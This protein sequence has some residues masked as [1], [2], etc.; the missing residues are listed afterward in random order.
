MEKI[1]AIIAFVTLGLVSGTDATLAEAPSFEPPAEAKIYLAKT[2]KPAFTRASAKPP[3]PRAKPIRTPPRARQSTARPAPAPKGF[4]TRMSPGG[5]KVANS[6]AR[7]TNPSRANRGRT[8]ASRAAVR[9]GTRGVLSRN[10]FNATAQRGALRPKFN[11]SASGKRNIAASGGGLGGGKT[12]RAAA[13]PKNPN[14]LTR[15]FNRASRAN[16]IRPKF[17]RAAVPRGNLGNTFQR[18]VQKGKA[19]HSFRKAAAQNTKSYPGVPGGKHKITGFTKHG[20]NQVINRKVSPRSLLDAVRNPGAGSK[21]FV[22]GKNKGTTRFVGRNS[23]VVLNNQG[24]V[25]TAWPRKPKNWQ[26]LPR[27]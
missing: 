18:S 6:T 4:G 14:S 19:T 21:M 1:L 11:Q 23:T 26:P 24:R 9:A 7:A 2:I 16:L 25:V 17:N 12:L 5:R 3:V 20:I 13:S 8:V 15:Q 22:A 27:R 10:A